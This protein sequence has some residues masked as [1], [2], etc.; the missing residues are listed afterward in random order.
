MSRIARV[1]CYPWMVLASCCVECGLHHSRFDYE[2][3][4]KQVNHGYDYDHALPY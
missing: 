3:W 4:E 1:T 2:Y